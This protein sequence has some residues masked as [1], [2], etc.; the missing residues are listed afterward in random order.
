[1][2]GIETGMTLFIAEK[3]GIAVNGNL[4]IVGAG[5]SARTDNRG[6]QGNWHGSDILR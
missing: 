1:M 3:A 6:S 5:N 2:H 4:V